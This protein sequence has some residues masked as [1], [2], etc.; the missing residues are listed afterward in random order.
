VRTL[1]DHHRFT[2]ISNV[3]TRK[4]TYKRTALRWYRQTFNKPIRK[5]ICPTPLAH[6][7]RGSLA[8]TV[9]SH[10][11]LV[12]M[13]L[14]PVNFIVSRT[15]YTVHFYYCC[16]TF[17]VYHFDRVLRSFTT[18]LYTYYTERTNAD[19]IQHIIRTTNSLFDERAN[20]RRTENTTNDPEA[21]IM[22]RINTRD[23]LVVPIPTS[24]SIITLDITTKNSIV[25]LHRSFVRIY[26]WRCAQV[27][28]SDIFVIVQEND[29]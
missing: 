10:L 1:A 17:A 4:H 28:Q 3:Y 6:L 16:T 12:F 20:R 25:S 23:I 21:S 7:R 15:H 5:L 9:R 13:V 22:L 8:H 24:T 18:Q 27:W 14:R 29:F 11:A 2:F 19:V 26:R